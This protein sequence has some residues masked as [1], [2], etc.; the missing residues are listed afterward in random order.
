MSKKVLVVDDDVDI[1]EGIALILEIE[2]YTVSTIAKGEKT[3]K[4]VEEFQPDL[5]LLDI[6]MFGTDGRAICKRLKSQKKT[7]H[8]P[9]ILVSA[10]PST[11]NA[12]SLS[13]AND[14]L[15]KPFDTVDL[16]T[17]VRKF[18]AESTRDART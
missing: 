10:D 13:S 4:R 11:K 7:K 1:L 18:T 17:L 2:G 6:R 12:K 3:Y 16:I 15:A 8:I 9:V 14:F 5:V